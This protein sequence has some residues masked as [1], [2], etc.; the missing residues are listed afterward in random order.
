MNLSTLESLNFMDNHF[1]SEERFRSRCSIAYATEPTNP[2]VSTGYVVANTKTIVD[3]IAKLGW[4]P[5]TAWQQRR[6]S[7]RYSFHSVVFENPDLNEENYYPRLILTNSHDGQHAFKFYMALYRKEY[8][9]GLG[10]ILNTGK[11]ENLYIRHIAYTFEEL[12]DL[13]N[14]VAEEL[15]NQL[16]VINTMIETTLTLEQKRSFANDMFKIRRNI[17][18]EVPFMLPEDSLKEIYGEE[19]RTNTNNLWEV[20]SRLQS[21]LI[22]GGFTYASE[23]TGKPRKLRLIKSA[24]K[25]IA[26]S[27]KLFK[28]AMS[29]LNK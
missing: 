5:V 13:T 8:G 11:F 28:A 12:R 23:R 6:R 7:G 15:P 16:T 26:V 27:K 3:D 17:P 10:I 2:D 19:W 20:F 18:V 25:D 24:A 29:Y 4:F 14:T 22:N 1:L 21:V 9:T